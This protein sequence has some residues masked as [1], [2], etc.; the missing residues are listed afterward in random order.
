MIYQLLH[1]LLSRVISLF[2]F[3]IPEVVERKK[4]ELKNKKEQGSQSFKQIGV[5]ADFCFE[6]ASEGELAQ[7]NSLVEDLL[8]MGKKIELVFFSPS[9]EKQVLSLYKKYPEQIRY[10]RY[11]IL[12][13]RF[14]SSCF[15][16]TRWISSYTL[17]LV[18]Y[19][20]FP[21]FL[22]WSKKPGNTLKL[23]WL[24][25]KKDR[26]KNKDLSSLKK[27]FLKASFFNVFATKEDL[28]Y[29]KPLGV[30]G[31]VYD[32]R[33]EQIYRRK[34]NRD[35]KFRAVFKNYDSLMSHLKTFPQQLI[36]GNAWKS[37]LHL[38]EHVTEKTSILIVPHKLD[39]NNLIELQLELDKMGLE[40]QLVDDETVHFESQILI[41]NKKGV[42]CELYGDFSHA[43]VG[44][45]F[46]VS[47]HS[48]LEPLVNGVGAIS[49]GPVNHRSTEV[50]VAKS[51]H[52]LT[53]VH[54]ADEFFQW[55]STE[56]CEGMIFDSSKYQ[57]YRKEVIG[58]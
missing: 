32:F 9:V 4:F 48:I 10:L 42:L 31:I 5:T 30:D 52:V 57:I 27:A 56:A 51:H 1:T 21:E 23:L 40:A 50:D 19:D 17:F 7:V 44:G 3:W 24:S 14:W 6:F 38:L 53:E 29:V 43:Y 37:D 18:R 47:I 46:G 33:M 36:F 54:S 26:L 45:G 22:V 11:P 16:F 58:C 25:F 15:N 28:D 2:I 41:L 35:D 55:L 12:T 20:F 39:Q 8:E 13:Y 49:C 34:L